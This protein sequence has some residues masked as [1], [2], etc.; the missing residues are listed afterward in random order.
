[1][2][3]FLANVGPNIPIEV[4]YE[5]VYC[6]SAVDNPT[7]NLSITATSDEVETAIAQQTEN[8][9][10]F[11]TTRNLAFLQQKGLSR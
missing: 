1:M 2:D 5:L 3:K 4:V 7:D 6:H 10:E 11:N 9:R 8:L